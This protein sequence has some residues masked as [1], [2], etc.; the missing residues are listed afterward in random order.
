M[1]AVPQA[2]RFGVDGESLW[3]AVTKAKD[4]RQSAGPLDEGI[5]VW[6]AAIEMEAVHLAIRP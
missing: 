5:V 4:T 6:D 3:V 2:I 1:L